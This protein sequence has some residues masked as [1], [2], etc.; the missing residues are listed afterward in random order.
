MQSFYLDNKRFPK[1]IALTVK[2]CNSKFSDIRDMITKVKSGDD[3]RFCDIDASYVSGE[4]NLNVLYRYISG[5]D[6]ENALLSKPGDNIYRYS[7][8]E[9]VIFRD[10][11]VDSNE[12]IERLFKDAAS[13]ETI[14]FSKPFCKFTWHNYDSHRN[15]LPGFMTF[16]AQT[17]S[18]LDYL[19]LLDSD[20]PQ[21]ETK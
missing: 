19:K 6:S 7:E 8:D 3:F 14:D 17:E 9:T 1:T 2:T 18:P 12:M 11:E 5:K 20:Q 15:G 10:I 4:N 16:Y 13:T 21:T